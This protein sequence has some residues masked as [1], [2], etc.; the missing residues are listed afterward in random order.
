[1]KRS[2]GVRQIGFVR[3]CLRSIGTARAT[4]KTVK[5]VRYIAGIRC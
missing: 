3:R 1:M 4:V 5:I 2:T